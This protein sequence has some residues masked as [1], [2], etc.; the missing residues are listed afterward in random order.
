MPS[1]HPNYVAVFGPNPESWLVGHGRRYASKNLN[2]ELMKEISNNNLPI[3]HVGF[4]TMDPTGERWFGRNDDTGTCYFDDNFAKELPDIIEIAKNHK[5]EAVTLGP[6]ATLI[7]GQTGTSWS[8]RYQNGF[9]VVP[10]QTIKA[11]IQQAQQT[12]TGDFGNRFKGILFG[13]GQSHILSFDTGFAPLLNE[14]TA[15][16]PDHPLFKILAE[17]KGW[18]LLPGSTLCHWDDRYFM[19]LF[20]HPKTSQVKVHWSLPN[21]MHQQLQDLMQ[22][23]DSPEDQAFFQKEQATKLAKQSA[24]AHLQFQ[25]N[26]HNMT[27]DVMKNAGDSMKLASGGYI[28]VQKW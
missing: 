10:S 9:Q 12:I 14:Q 26:L 23:T 4:L 8:V 25:Q 6:S 28:S 18:T 7:D 17:Y 1:I 24:L 21:E 11:S 22:L 15:T 20:K 16:D 19:F 13:Y 3:H 2:S 5:I 27:L